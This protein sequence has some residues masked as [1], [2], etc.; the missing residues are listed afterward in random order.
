MEGLQVFEVAWRGEA[1]G[2]VARSIIACR[3]TVDKV[4]A[5]HSAACG[6]SPPG[7]A[8]SAYSKLLALPSDTG[9][10][11]AGLPLGLSAYQ[12]KL[13]MAIYVKARELM[14]EGSAAEQAVEHTRAP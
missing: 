14:V 1:Q 5:P 2:I 6:C 12:K 3:W 13:W 10:I 8:G 11:P 7:S 4:C 9:M